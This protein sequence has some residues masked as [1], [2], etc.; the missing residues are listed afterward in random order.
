MS[1]SSP[2][3]LAA[4]VVAAFVSNNRLPAGEL[5]ALIHAVHTSVRN[6]PRGRRAQRQK[7]RRRPRR[8][9]SESRS[10]RIF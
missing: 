5:P 7:S 9:Q 6:S 8:F 3:E 10:R 2:I 1:G 4:D